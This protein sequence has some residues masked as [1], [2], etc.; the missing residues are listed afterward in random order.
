M[1]PPCYVYGS[2]ITAQ[3]VAAIKARFFPGK[4]IIAPAAAMLAGIHARFPM[5]LEHEVNRL[6]GWAFDA[7]DEGFSY[8]RIEECSPTTSATT[9][10]PNTSAS[11]EATVT[12]TTNGEPSGGPS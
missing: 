6:R 7:G 4:Q 10:Q 3:E 5:R 2:P 1:R 9:A 12:S 11:T 8:E